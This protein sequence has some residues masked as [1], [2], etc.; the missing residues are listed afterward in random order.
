MYS[1][2]I[3]YSNHQ[4]Q[5]QTYPVKKQEKFISKFENGNESLAKN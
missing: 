4:I 1:V 3:F 2:V 5:Y